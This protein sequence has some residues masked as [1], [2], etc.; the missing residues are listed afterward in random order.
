MA[1]NK[2]TPPAAD[3]LRRR[4][5]EQLVAQGSS[6]VT[7]EEP[8]KLLHEL[9]VHQVEL[10]LQNSELQRARDETAAL[11]EQYTEL[12]DFA[13]VGYFT[14]DR[15]GAICSSNLTGARLLGMARSLL[16]GR[17]FQ[18]FIDAASRPPFSAL[19]DTVFMNQAK[20][21]CEALLL[22]QENSPCC[23]QIEAVTDGSGE[24]C[25]LA[26]IDISE[27]KRLEREL[28]R[29][30][31]EIS[32]LKQQ[33]DAENISLRAELRNHLEQGQLLGGSA[34]LRKVLTQANQLA[35]TD[36]TV[37][38]QGETGTGKELIA[39]YI[40]QQSGRCRRNLYPLSCAAIPATL[41]ESELFGHEKGAFTGAQERRLGHF[42]LADHAT[43]FL[44]EI[45]E[46]AL[47][48]QAKLLRVLQE[49]E[50]CRVGSTKTIKTDARV[51]AA[52]NRNLAEE[53]RQGRFREDLYYRL[54]VFPLTIPPLRERSEDIPLLVW[55]FVHDLG[56]R[57]GKNITKISTSDMTSLQEYSWPGNIRELRNVIEHSLIFSKD[58]TLLINLPAPSSPE[59][60][61]PLSLHA[62]EY[63]HITAILQSTNWRVYGLKGA[64][65]LLGLHPNTLYSR[66]KKLGIPSLRGID[67]IP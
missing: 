43:I 40:H 34:P 12:Y 10:E 37:L 56:S 53:V 67:E 24:Q 59:N 27:R 33:V 16:N 17:R 11:L 44:D 22:T 46:L 9:Q 23:V 55:A 29:N 7:F 32:T 18:Q 35:Q 15:R 41:M 64:A 45:G 25:R 20:E 62:M 1:K 28:Q 63:Q 6:A 36:I 8:L 26:V 14:L 21:S 58:E 52:T 60:C 5:K 42:E 51:I 65:R 38:L 66:M 50:F 3:E 13:P 31:K 39:R 48:A 2:D 61:R 54:S 49:G 30:V 47:E 57:M 4:A 19:L